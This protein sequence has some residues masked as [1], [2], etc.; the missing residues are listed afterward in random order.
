MLNLATAFAWPWCCCARAPLCPWCEPK[1]EQR[2]AEAGSS[3]RAR[4][5][6]AHAIIL[7]RCGCTAAAEDIVSGLLVA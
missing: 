5:E 6:D 1:T 4:R 7:D 2:A 3:T